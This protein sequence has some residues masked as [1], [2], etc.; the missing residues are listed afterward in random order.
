MA[1]IG[2]NGNGNNYINGQW[3]AKKAIVIE[4][5]GGIWNVMAAAAMA[6]KYQKTSMYVGVSIESSSVSANGQ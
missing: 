3:P 4:A 2:I 1:I 6:A 5:A